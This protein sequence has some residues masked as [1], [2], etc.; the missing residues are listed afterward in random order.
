MRKR[1]LFVWLHDSLS[2]LNSERLK[3]ETSALSAF[4]LLLQP[5]PRPAS[6]LSIRGAWDRRAAEDWDI[7]SE[8]Q[9]FGR[10]LSLTPLPRLQRNCRVQALW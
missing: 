2:S 9:P 5:S 6:A 4:Y 10:M 1:M 3:A 8:R 7:I